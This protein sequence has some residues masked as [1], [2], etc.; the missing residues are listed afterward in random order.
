MDASVAAI[1]V[2]RVVIPFR[3][4]DYGACEMRGRG[5]NPQEYVRIKHRD[6]ARLK[7]NM[8]H[9]AGMISVDLLVVPTCPAVSSPE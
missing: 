1:V 6:T 8:S 3:T 9:A 2:L 5:R 7:L 4:D